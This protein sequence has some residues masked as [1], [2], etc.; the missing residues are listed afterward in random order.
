MTPTFHFPDIYHGDHA[1]SFHDMAAAGIPLVILKA[2]EGTAYTD[3][4]FAARAARVR[5]VPGLA[6]GAYAF[7]DARPGP[8]QAAHFLSAAH[9]QPGDLQP[10]VDAEKLGLTKAETFAALT[11]LEGRGY[12]PILYASLSFWRDVLGSP[13]RWALWLAAYCATLPAL[14]DDVTL[15]AWQHSENSTCPGVVGPC[16][17]SYAYGNLSDYLIGAVVQPS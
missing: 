9:L 11:D 4:A 13:T 8:P 7:L 10:V 1:V 6:L 16:D 3:P 2:T 5:S 17:M 14:P 12:R 15:F